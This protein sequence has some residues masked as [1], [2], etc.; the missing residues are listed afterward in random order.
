MKGKLFLFLALFTGL[1]CIFSFSVC[2]ISGVSSNEFGEV[3]EITGIE[4]QLK[5]KTSRVVLI[6]GDG[7]YTTYYTY[8]IA[9]KLQWQGTSQYDFTALNQK[10]GEN[11]T[12]NSIVR[13]EIM[14]DTTI[15]N[16]NGGKFQDL[17][18]FVEMV[19]PKGT[20]ITSLP[21]QLF[22]CSSIQKIEIPKTITSMGVN[23][24]EGC[25]SL[26]DVTFEEGFSMTKLP[27][28]MFNGCSSL[29]VIKIPESVT[30]MGGSTFVNC[31]SLK[32]VYLSPNLTSMESS[33]AMTPQSFSIYA[34][35]TFLKGETIGAGHFSWAG[36]EP[37]RVTLFITGDKSV[38]ENIV[39]SAIHKPVKNA[40]L[41]D[42]DPT[43]DDS[44]YHTVEGEE[45]W[46]IV[47][48]YSPCNAFYDGVHIEGVATVYD[49]FLEEGYHS[50]GCTRRGCIFGETTKLAPIFESY[51]YS[52][53][54][55]GD[56]A[57]SQGFF[58]NKEAL[59]IYNS[60]VEADKQISDYGV[61][62]VSEAKGYTQAFEKGVAKTGVWHFSYNGKGQSSFEIRASGL[63][64]YQST[65]LY[66]CSYLKIGENYLYVT[67]K[68]QSS[69]LSG[70]VSYN[71]IKN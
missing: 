5:D 50:V 8:Y 6:N 49:T 68:I 44:F 38:A 33:F 3:T 39:N 64:N 16:Q 13:I 9:Q 10:T 24:F 53:K 23:L 47:Y 58:I 71:S 22:R 27:R 35:A 55:Y 46:N 56:C 21:D 42:W 52:K 29:E 15:I 28:Q 7:T 70:A 14:T 54:S 45:H 60:L 40:F 62:A 19:F 2:A 32:K 20:Q 25:K 67:N 31:S 61:L 59:A 51:G 12:M 63:N 4:T 18:N 37:K 36:N 48:N 43:K 17:T 65:K 41:Y 57:I 69:T 11:Y 30:E 1:L 34:P 66:L 26:I